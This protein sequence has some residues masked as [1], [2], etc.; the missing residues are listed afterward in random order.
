[1]AWLV[2]L[3]D[4]DAK[5]GSLVEFCGDAGNEGKIAL[6]KDTANESQVAF[7][8]VAGNKVQEMDV[9]VLHGMPG[10]PSGGPDPAPL[11]RQP[12]K[13]YNAR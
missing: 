8:E 12:D 10:G 9:G 1:M 7:F 2:C 3:D 5:D 11:D 6:V 13:R 4:D